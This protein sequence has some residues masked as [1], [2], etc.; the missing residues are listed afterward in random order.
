MGACGGGDSS[1]DP[2]GSL[3]SCL[4]DAGLE[5]KV[6]SVAPDVQKS[7]NEVGKLSIET[8]D[9]FMSVSVFAT[10]KAAAVYAKGDKD[11]TRY[12]S[13]IFTYIKKGP[14]VDKVV[15]CVDST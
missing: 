9:N 4:G 5:V 10:P 2:L 14:D 1:D 7:L 6:E 13:N 11:Y 12:G 15:R 3:Q 8:S